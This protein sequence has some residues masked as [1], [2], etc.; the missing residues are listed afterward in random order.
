MAQLLTVFSNAFKE[1]VPENILTDFFNAVHDREWAL[2]LQLL[3]QNPSEAEVWSSRVAYDGDI[4]WKRL[5]IHEACINNAPVNLLEALLQAY[6]ES[7]AATDLTKRLPLH[8]AA[9]HGADP[10]VVEFLVKACPGAVNATDTYGKT[11]AMCLMGCNS[12]YSETVQILSTP[13]EGK[14]IATFGEEYNAFDENLSADDNST[15]LFKAIQ[16][17]R[18]ENTMTLIESN[19]TEVR[20]WTTHKDC[21]GEVV[22]KRLPIHEACINNAPVYV[23]GSLIRAYQEGA[24]GADLNKRLPLHHVAVHGGKLD[25]IELLLTAYPDSLEKKDSFGKTPIKCL[26][27]PT[28][29][30]FSTH[31]AKMEALSKDPSFYKDTV[32]RKLKAN[33]S[34]IR[35]LEVEEL[36]EELERKNEEQI[37]LNKKLDA[38]LTRS[39]LLEEE[40]A[41][42][43][44]ENIQ[45]KKALNN[46]QH[47]YTRLERDVL[48]QES[49][50]ISV[51]DEEKEEDFD[52]LVGTSF[53]ATQQPFHNII[54][55]EK[56]LRNLKAEV[57]E[58]ESILEQA[59][60]RARSP[61][62]S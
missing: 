55:K 1:D 29:S 61:L 7:V 39:N 10:R 45:L 54:V 5:P 34:K 48:N 19:S 49:L 26:K 43:F 32:L 6:P 35:D 27:S 30:D 51:N 25:V 56:N 17:K 36:K 47:E 12:M 33:A 15:D 21:D 16:D 2:A 57:K 38:I 18:W 8:H 22:W 44:S 23:I 58:R 40:M 37:K 41:E 3:E 62:R 4:I 13:F 31:C 46:L 11:P 14:T 59:L 28:P 20:Q 42:K 60:L 24:K 52:P 9:A 50:T 53:E